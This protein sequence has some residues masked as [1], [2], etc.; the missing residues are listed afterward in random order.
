[1]EHGT[2]MQNLFQ[3]QDLTPILEWKHGTGFKINMDFNHQ[4]SK[5]Q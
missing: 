4:Q 5:Y 2:A 1:M 3:S